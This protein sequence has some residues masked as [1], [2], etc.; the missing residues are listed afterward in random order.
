MFLT[1]VLLEGTQVLLRNSHRDTKKGD[2]MKPRWLGPYT[3]HKHLKKGVY[4]LKNQNGDLLKSGI[5]QFR[6]KVYHKADK[7]LVR[8]SDKI[9]CNI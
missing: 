7:S 8:S 5:N 1:Q 2:K 3:I 4:H 9:L 6:L